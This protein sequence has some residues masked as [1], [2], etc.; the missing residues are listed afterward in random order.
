MY[1]NVAIVEQPMRLDY[2]VVGQLTSRDYTTANN[3]VLRRSPNR[4]GT[5]FDSQ[6]V[7][8]SVLGIHFVILGPVEGAIRV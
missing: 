1:E 7:G 8:R 4:K 3:L 5:V 2:D 6:V